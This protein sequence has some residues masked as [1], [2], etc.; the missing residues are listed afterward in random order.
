MFASYSLVKHLLCSLFE[1]T[2]SIQIVGLFGSGSR[3]TIRCAEVLR[4]RLSVLL[5]YDHALGVLLIRSGSVALISCSS[6]SWR[7]T[8]WLFADDIEHAIFQGFFI[9]GQP[10]LLP[11]IVKDARILLVSGHTAFKKVD[12]G[13]I[14]GL[15]FKLKRTTVLHELKELSWVTLAKFFKRSLDLL[16]LDVVILFVL[17][18]T[19]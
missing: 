5:I 19:W 7:I 6:A 12:T 4:C 15:L 9:F 2:A 18:A 17:G 1:F 16:F 8:L 3:C 11:G 13:A 10:V 14:V